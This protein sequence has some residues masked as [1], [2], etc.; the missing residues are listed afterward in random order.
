MDDA[1][2]LDWVVGPDFLRDELQQAILQLPELQGRVMALLFFEDLTE[3]LAAQKL[4]LGQPAVNRL[5][6][7]GL[8]SL[9]K[10][11][12]EKRPAV[13]APISPKASGCAP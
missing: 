2:R 6:R 8:D 3:T 13:P 11:L 4:G 1:T 9:R 10:Y 7:A 5:K 12:R